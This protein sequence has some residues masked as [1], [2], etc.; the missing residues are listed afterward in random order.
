MNKLTTKINTLYFS[1]LLILAISLLIVWKNVFVPFVYDSEQTKADLLLS[2]YAPIFE[3]LLG[4][5]KM[6]ELQALVTNMMLLKDGDSEQPLILELNLILEDGR[7]ITQVNGS[8]ESIFKN[9][10]SLFSPLNLELLGRL[11]IKYNDHL[12]N[13]IIDDSNTAIWVAVGVL[14]VLFFVGQALLRW[15]IHPLSYLSNH[16]AGIDSV[17]VKDIPHINRRLSTEVA[18]VWHAS[19]IMF[20]RIRQRE[21]EIKAEHEIA[22]NALQMKLEAEDANKAKSQFLANMSHELR[23]PLNAIIGYSELM[24]DDLLENGQESMVP[25][26]KKIQTSGRH[27]LS[28]INDI[29]DLSKVEAGKM[30][31]FLE[32][33]SIRDVVKEI[34][35]TI[36][37]LIL[38]GGNQFHLEMPNIDITMH[39]DITK[40]K[41]NLINLLSNASKFTSNGLITLSVKRFTGDND[42]FI[43]FSVSDTGIGM[44][45]DHLEKLF[46]P[47]SQADV[48]TTRKYGGTGLGLTITQKFCHMLGGSIL[49]RSEP[50]MGSTFTLRL[51]LNSEKK[52]AVSGIEGYKLRINTINPEMLRFDLN[53]SKPDDRRQRISTVLVIDDDISVLDV[54]NSVLS[55][56]GFNVVT[57]SSGEK[58]MQLAAELLPDTIILDVIMPGFGGWDVLV[59][60][61][62]EPLTACIPV[63]MTSLEDEKAATQ[64][65][66]VPFFVRKP[67]DK[68]TILRNVKTCV[69]K[70]GAASVLV[71]ENQIEIRRLFRSVFEEQGW[72]VYEAADAETGVKLAI[73]QFP[74]L[75]I[76]DMKFPDKD[77]GELIEELKSNEKT[78]HIPIIVA[79]SFDV[80]APELREFHDNIVGFFQKGSYS[81]EK[82][83]NEIDTILKK[84]LEQNIK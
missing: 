10:T 21:R 36:D 39:S 70:Q 1:T 25:D 23:T 58:G 61:R 75:I 40:L 18:N 3:H 24:E 49:V 51:P 38:K 31:V 55:K 77:G 5:G 64:A 19:E 45:K 2:P 73:E 60:L 48:S 33:F 80:D 22:Q 71:I 81:I 34:V 32:S 4:E 27:L 41:Q 50:K 59:H 44:D 46:Q 78:T 57:A 52:K 54:M 74:K 79:S 9:D 8:E 30:D 37:P 76:T 17:D 53:Q 15:F 66:G 29:L 42:R 43:D 62:A 35:S 63:I 12:Y 67:I 16:L 11:E 47:F 13:R 65:M 68:Q 14:G 7:R 6:E 83:V 26:I 20:A 56:D 28:L 72:R 84:Q 82:L 69:R